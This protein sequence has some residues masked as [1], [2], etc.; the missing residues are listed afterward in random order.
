Y[1]ATEDGLFVSMDGGQHWYGEAVQ[2]E[3]DLIAVN[4]LGGSL[5]AISPRRAFLSQDQGK[6]W[7]EMQVP[8][9]VTGIYNLT[10]A[11]DQVLWMGTREGALRSSDGG[12]TWVHVLGGLPPR[13]VFAVN[14]DAAGQRLLATARYARGVFES[15]DG[16]KTW[17]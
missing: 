1:A 14:Y 2:G 11:P 7:S 15:K 9:Y 5:G 12:K 3:S 13:H 10:M 8:Q 6:T 16:G 17:Q 4:D